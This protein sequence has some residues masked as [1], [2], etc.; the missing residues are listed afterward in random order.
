MKKQG[1]KTKDSINEKP[2]K[3]DEETKRKTDL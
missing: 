2:S 3:L 1:E